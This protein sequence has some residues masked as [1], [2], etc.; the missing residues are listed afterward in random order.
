MLDVFWIVAPAPEVF[1]PAEIAKTEEGLP[2]Y[3]YDTVPVTN[4]GQLLN[5]RFRST[6]V[7]EHL[8]ARDDVGA[9][10]GERQHPGIGADTAGHGKPLKSPH[11]LVVSKFDSDQRA[12]V[13][14]HRFQRQSFANTDV[15]PIALGGTCC[16]PQFPQQTGDQSLHDNIAAAVFRLILPG[17]LD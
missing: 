1:S 13:N 12:R 6:E 10:I 11:Q 8:E 17:C 2:R 7:L 15:D 5:S 16:H 14:V 3:R 9:A 4:A